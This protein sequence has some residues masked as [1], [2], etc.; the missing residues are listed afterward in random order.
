MTYALRWARVPAVAATS[1]VWRVVVVRDKVNADCPGATAGPACVEACPAVD[2]VPGTDGAVRYSA[3]CEDIEL[4][5]ILSSAPTGID[6]KPGRPP[7]VDGGYTEYGVRSFA[8]REPCTG[9]RRCRVAWSMRATI[10][11]PGTGSIDAADYDW[12]EDAPDRTTWPAC[13]G[14]RAGGEP[15]R[16]GECTT[17]WSR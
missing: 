7:M 10:D 4:L 16:G 15:E 11:V 6:T 5:G 8:L 13:G 17:T 2:E 3:R 14:D 1:R 9:E 12:R